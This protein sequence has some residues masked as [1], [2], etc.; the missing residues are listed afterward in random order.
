MSTLDNGVTMAG[1]SDPRVKSVEDQRETPANDP[2]P[3][4]AETAQRTPQNP[5]QSRV[6]RYGA[7]TPD[8]TPV[9][10]GAAAGA[11]GRGWGDGAAPRDAIFVH[12]D[13]R[14][15]NLRGPSHVTL[16]CGSVTR[17]WRRR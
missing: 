2:V 5:E 12:A 17:T 16:A 1:P 15:A 8:R 13:L 11:R 4:R 9:E 10:R 3:R 14:G 6:G 7:I